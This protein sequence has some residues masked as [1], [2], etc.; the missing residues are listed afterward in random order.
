MRVS[1][2]HA[3]TTRGYTTDN[4]LN[5]LRELRKRFGDSLAFSIQ[6]KKN[7]TED[8]IVLH[9]ATVCVCAWVPSSGD[10]D[11]RASKNK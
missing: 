8:S 3:T 1:P 10:V 11:H 9:L 2:S 5:R 6:Q 4:T 7:K